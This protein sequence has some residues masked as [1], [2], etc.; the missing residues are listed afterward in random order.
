MT[1][2]LIV[3]A[4]CLLVEAFFSGSEMA[5]VAADRLKLERLATAGSRGARILV[6]F[7]EQPQRLLATTLVGTQLAV[8]TATIVIT[9]QVLTNPRLEPRAE[10]LTIGLLSPVL[11][12][13]AEVVPKTLFQQHADAIAPR[14]AWPLALASLAFSPFVFV[15]TR[16]TQAVTRVLRIEEHRAVITR[17]ELEL[18]LRAPTAEGEITEGERRMITRI[19]DFGETTVYDVMVPLSEVFALPDDASLD[20]A[21]REVQEKR[22]TRIPVYRERVD[23]IVGV[24]HSFDLLKAGARTGSVGELAKPG[25]YVPEGQAAIDLLVRLQRERQGMAVVV[26][27]YGG[28]IGIVTIEDIL[29]EIVGEIEDEYDTVGPSPIRQE[30]PGLYRVQGRTSIAQVNQATRAQ[31]PEGEDYETVAGLLLDRLKRI[32]REG[33]TVRVGNAVITIVGASERTIEEV[34]IKIR[35]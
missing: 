24:V 27:E 11:L 9:V 17:E 10:L 22:H 8:V 29:E 26:D 32:P 30:G 20:E 33:E 4:I 2:A 1:G 3:A 25:I 13:F 15:M 14:V 21:V 12:I 18:L 31:L 7:L 19:F 28:A 23:Q 5:V 35:R 34:R 6:R 16:F